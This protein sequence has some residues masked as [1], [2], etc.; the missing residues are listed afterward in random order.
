MTLIT[1]SMLRSFSDIQNSVPLAAIALGSYRVESKANKTTIFLSHKHEESKV[2]LLAA[3]SF[4]KKF[5]VEVYVDWLDEEMPKVTSVET[6][7]KIKEK[8][9]QNNKFILLATEEAINSKWCNWELGLG[10]AAKYRNNIALLVV[11]KDNSHYSGSEY[12]NIYPYIAY[13]NGT[14]IYSNGAYIKG[15]YYVHYPDND[16]IIRLETWLQK[17]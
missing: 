17:S 5:G 1:E 11:Q 10:D 14:N 12:L 15:G 2:N 13:Q 9:R 3:I 7:R 8:I 4:L 6:A 16:T